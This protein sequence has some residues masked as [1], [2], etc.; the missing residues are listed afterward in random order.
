[1][2]GKVL[3]I[4]RG[5]PIGTAPGQNIEHRCPA[6]STLW[7]TSAGALVKCQRCGHTSR[8]AEPPPKPPPRPAPP[9]RLV[10]LIRRVR[11]L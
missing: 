9:G 6:C 7:I 5:A 1:M 10:A 8:A 11:P 3:T 2:T 4:K